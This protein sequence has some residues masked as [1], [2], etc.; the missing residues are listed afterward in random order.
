MK[1]AKN[2]LI[3]A[4]LLASSAFV[5]AAPAWAADADILRECIAARSDQANQE[6]VR[7]ECMWKHWDQMASWGR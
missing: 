4:A 6:A 2:R 7:S 3:A 5:S 1:T